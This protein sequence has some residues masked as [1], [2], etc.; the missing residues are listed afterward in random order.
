[1]AQEN[2]APESREEL[3]ET[4]GTKKRNL[5]KPQAVLVQKPFL[6]ELKRKMDDDGLTSTQL[7]RK[8]GI[9]YSYL[10]ALTSGQRLV[11]NSERSRVEKLA[12]YLDVP[13]VQVYI[14]GG[15]L[16]PKDFV[17]QDGLGKRIGDIFKIM[18]TDRALTGILPTDEDW[19]NRRIFSEPARLLVAQLYELFREGLHK[20]LNR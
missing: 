15:L 18:K 3:I 14:W 19:S 12:N 4:A 9:P 6:V 1:M 10:L 8:L 2:D 17:F 20:Q 16:N 11:V 5:T 13:I 7:A